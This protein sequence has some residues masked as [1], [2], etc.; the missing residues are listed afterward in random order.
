MQYAFFSPDGA[1]DL[2]AFRAQV[3]ACLRAGVQGI[4]IL[5]LATEVSKLTREERSALLEA[6][7]A[8]VGG[9]AP[10][11]VTVFGATPEEQIEFVREAER[12]GAPAL[13]IAL[14]VAVGWNAM[15][16]V[17]GRRRFRRAPK[18]PG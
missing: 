7:A 15:L 9:Q 16:T 1:L 8:A 14:A 3:G 10:L 12:A 18:P 11:S 17:L 4:A 2:A 6:A 5:G 13:L